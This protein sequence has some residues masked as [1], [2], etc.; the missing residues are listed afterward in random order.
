MPTKPR[1]VVSRLPDYIMAEQTV[2]GVERVI[3]LGQNELGID[4]SPAAV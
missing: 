4:P 2:D 1:E 3:Q